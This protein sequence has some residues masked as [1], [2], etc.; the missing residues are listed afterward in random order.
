VT[1]KSA[2]TLDFVM[3]SSRTSHT[4]TETFGE[5]LRRFRQAKGLTQTQLGQKA[6]ISKRMVA[7]YEIQGGTP[8]PELLVRLAEAL[9]VTTDALAGRKQGLRRDG[10]LSPESLRIWR[11][12]KRIEE[13]PVHDRKTIL[14]MIDAMA[15]VARRKAS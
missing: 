1:L 9:E 8:A 5:R 10:P 6:V 13:L 12:V 11:R 4:P 2:P 7:Y 3:A 15:D 14:K